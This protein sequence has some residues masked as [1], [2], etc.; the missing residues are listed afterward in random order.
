MDYIIDNYG[1][2]SSKKDGQVREIGRLRENIVSCVILKFL[3]GAEIS[4][5]LDNDYRIPEIDWG[6]VDKII[7]WMNK[8]NITQISFSGE[9]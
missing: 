3:N 8:S 5:K 2:L 9:E 4:V 6:L 7:R 1:M